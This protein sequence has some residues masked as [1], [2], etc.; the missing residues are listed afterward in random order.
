MVKLVSPSH[1]LFMFLSY[2][3]VKFTLS[4]IWPPSNKNDQVPPSNQPHQVPNDVFLSFRREDTC[5]I[6]VDHLYSALA[7][8]G[9]VVYKHHET[10]PR[11]EST[12]PSLFTA[13]EESKIAVI[14][15]SRNYAGSSTCLEELAYIM[16]CKDKRELIVMPI[17]Y[18]VDPSEVRK[19][20]GDFWKAFGKQKAQSTTKA[21]SWRRAL[22]HVSEIAGW[23][24]KA[25]TDRETCITEIVKSVSDRL[26][27][28]NTNVNESLVG[29]TTRLHNLK[30]Q[31]DIE[32]GGVRM[33]G[34]WGQF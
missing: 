30:S 13:I 10:L 23:E 14:I 1:L 3:L 24:P 21:E 11:D 32:S 9:I 28:L 6:F 25:F 18:D 26:L 17:F 16:E 22:V 20:K 15:L 2:K 19:Q 5:K 31:L 4:K 27:L 8:Q 29:M 33:V 12:S 7:Q 34:I